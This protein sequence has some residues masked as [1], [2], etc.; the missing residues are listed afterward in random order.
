[1]FDRKKIKLGLL[2]ACFILLAMSA[3]LASGLGLVTITFDLERIGGFSSNQYAVWIEDSNGNY[4]K[5]LSVTR[6]AANGGFNKRPATLPVWVK[7]S[8]WANRSQAEI[9]AVSTAT[10]G[11]GTITVQW[12]GTD[13]Q[14][15]FVPSGKYIYKIEANIF[16]DKRVLWS[17]IISVGQEA[18]SSVATAEYVPDKETVAQKG[19]LITNVKASY[20]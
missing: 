6:F 15:Q 11:T 5:T 1:V 18:N 20:K 14:G 17:G 7:V 12:D 9:D 4:I 13:S 3:V 8:D 2:L 10:P 16:M 19:L